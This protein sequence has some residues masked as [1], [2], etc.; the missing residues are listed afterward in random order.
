[1]VVQPETSVL[2]IASFPSFSNLLTLIAAM[3]YLG[4]VQ[5]FSIKH[6]AHTVFAGLFRHTHSCTQT[7]YPQSKLNIYMEKVLLKV[8]TKY[9]YYFATLLYITVYTCLYCIVFIRLLKTILAKISKSRGFEKYLVLYNVK[10]MYLKA[11]CVL[12]IF[13][14]LFFICL[15]L[16]VGADTVFYVKGRSLCTFC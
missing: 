2:L 15:R 6:L 14:L 4:Q 8:T 5:A 16:Y 10:C 11:C 13:S 3:L 7:S 12:G 9:I 1:M